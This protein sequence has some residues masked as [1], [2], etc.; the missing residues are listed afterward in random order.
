LPDQSLMMHAPVLKVHWV[1]E[2]GRGGDVRVVPGVLGVLPSEWA[3]VV[4][5]ARWV[6][7]SRTR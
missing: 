5:G 4:A 7:V 2:T 1:E 3:C 6:F